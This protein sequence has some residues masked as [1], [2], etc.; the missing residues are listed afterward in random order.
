MKKIIKKLNKIIYKI[1]TKRWSIL[2]FKNENYDSINEL[3]DFIKNI[4]TT[5]LNKDLRN[6]KIIK[7]AADPFLFKKKIFYEKLYWPYTKGYIESLNIRNLNK[8]TGYLKNFP[9]TSFPT[10]YEKN[11]DLFLLTESQSWSYPFF[12]KITNNVN[13]ENNKI[14]FKSKSYKLLDPFIFK[15]NNIYYLF[16][17]NNKFKKLLLFHSKKLFGPYEKHKNAL[18]KNNKDS[19]RSGGKI[20]NYKNEYYRIS[21]I[22][23]KSYGDGLAIYKIKSITTLCY[24][25][26]FVDHFSFNSRNGPHTLSLNSKYIALDFFQFSIDPLAKFKRLIQILSRFFKNVLFS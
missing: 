12:Y 11:S 1:F 17:T 21:Q 6:P 2:I 5:N 13:N 16:G 26:E 24:R 23:Q 20:F 15:K 18:F 14:I 9:H 10:V 22:S 8:K 7:N 3:I 4:N 25:E 19:F